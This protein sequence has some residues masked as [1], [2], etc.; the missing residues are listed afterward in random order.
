[1]VDPYVAVV[2]NAVTTKRKKD[3]SWHLHGLG[4]GG[5]WMGMGMAAF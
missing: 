2:P 5:L 3:Q 4:P 1:M